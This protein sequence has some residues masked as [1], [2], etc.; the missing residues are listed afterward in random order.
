MSAIYGLLGAIG[1]LAGLVMTA[2]AVNATMIRGL[3]ISAAQVTQVYSEATFYGVMAI[4]A[5]AFA[6]VMSIL[7]LGEYLLN[8]IRLTRLAQIPNSTSPSESPEDRSKKFSNLG[9]L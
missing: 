6:A 2:L 1:L 7:L 4:V 8:L 5:F 3:A 9:K